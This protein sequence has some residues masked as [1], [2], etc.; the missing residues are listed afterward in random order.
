MQ[1]AILS[2]VGLVAGVLGGL[3]GVGG[4]VV[5]IPAMVWVFSPD[6]DIQQYQA[7]AMIV[8]F[9]LIG[10]SVLRHARAKAIYF[11]VWKYL[12]PAA[13]IGILVGVATSRLDIFTGE[14]Q[15][16]M[17]T[18]FGA[19]MIYV[20][21]YN[22]WKMRSAE[23]EGITAEEAERVAWVKKAGVGLPMGFSA[24]LLAMRQRS[25]D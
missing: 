15:V 17:K 19:F 5:M 3:M 22:L 23:S 12:A 25:D 8:N 14:N 20:A 9:L 21:A 18:L 10:P 4:S 16:Y 11:G 7:A 1:Y 13:I 24:G 2:I 6:G